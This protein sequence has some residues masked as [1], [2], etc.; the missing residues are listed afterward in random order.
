MTFS[1]TAIFVVSDSGT[2]EVNIILKIMLHNIRI[3]T[4]AVTAHTNS[5]YSFIRLGSFGTNDPEIVYV[6]GIGC[7]IPWPDSK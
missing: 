5:V 6:L 2:A 1:N 7:V 3:L 4:V